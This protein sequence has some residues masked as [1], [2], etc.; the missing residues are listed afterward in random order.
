MLLRN[1][2]TNLP[3]NVYKSG[4]FNVSFTTSEACPESKA[5]VLITLKKRKVVSPNIEPG[6]VILFQN[7][8]PVFKGTVYVNY[9]SIPKDVAD[10]TWY[11]S[12]TVWCGGTN[13]TVAD[14]TV[15]RTAADLAKDQPDIK[16]TVSGSA[17]GNTVESTVKPTTFESYEQLKQEQSIEIKNTPE[18]TQAIPVV[19]PNVTSPL[20]TE[21]PPPSKN[22]TLYYIIGAVIVAIALYMARKPIKKLIKLK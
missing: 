3:G 1:L 20:E 16:P 7:T 17:I 9:L 19:S 4:T 10:G 15:S 6:D 21:P 11:M 12:L 5:K 13:G 18:G 8:I 14:I 22:K 2:T